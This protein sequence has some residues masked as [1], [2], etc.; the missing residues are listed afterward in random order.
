[1][2]LLFGSIIVF[3][4]IAYKTVKRISGN[5]IVHIWLFTMFFQIFFDVF[6]SLK[7]KGYWYFGKGVDLISVPVYILLI[8][9]VNLIF[10]NWFPFNSSLLIKLRYFIIW[11][12]ITLTYEAITML[13]HPYGYFHYGWWNMWYSMSINPVL[14]IILLS[15]YKWMSKLEKE[16]CS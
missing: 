7:Y 14:L 6:V 8:P 3:N 11:E 2:I 4:V 15:Y 16:A 1:M 10:I 9:P 5:K 13:P 12:I